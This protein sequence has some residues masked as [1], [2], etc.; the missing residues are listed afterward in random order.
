MTEIILR[1]APVRTRGKFGEE[2]VDDNH[3]NTAQLEALLVFD[4]ATPP[5]DAVLDNP[6]GL[7]KNT[8]AV[9]SSAAPQS[10][11]YVANEWIA[12]LGGRT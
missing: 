1:D 11:H 7:F 2:P 10:K 8:E 12:A 6:P 9:A 4:G 3:R 5:E